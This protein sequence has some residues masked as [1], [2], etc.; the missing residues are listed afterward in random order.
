MLLN[1][2]EPI[3]FCRHW[4]VTWLGSHVC[5]CRG[6]GKIGHWY[7][8]GYVLWQRRHSD[9]SSDEDN[10]ADFPLPDSFALESPQ[11]NGERHISQLLDRELFESELLGGG[12]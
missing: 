12:V 10:R 6:C 4:D 3:V 2:V 8:D 5:S 11:P 7:E 9:E 1:T